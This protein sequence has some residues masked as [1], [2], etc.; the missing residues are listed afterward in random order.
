MNLSKFVVIALLL[1]E[2]QQVATELYNT[3]FPLYPTLATPNT[4]ACDNTDEMYMHLR[5]SGMW[6]VHQ[7]ITASTVAIVASATH[8]GL[9]TYSDATGT[10]WFPTTTAATNCSTSAGCAA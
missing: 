10:A 3:N 7:T 1:G 9:Y 2:T 6:G 4:G 5:N 8:R